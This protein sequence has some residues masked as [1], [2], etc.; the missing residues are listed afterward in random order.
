MMN[1]GLINHLQY[2]SVCNYYS[3]K[4]VPDTDIVALDIEKDFERVD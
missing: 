4:D 1:R 2:K 3:Y